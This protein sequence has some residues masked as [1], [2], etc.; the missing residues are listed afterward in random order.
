MD[1]VAKAVPE[2]AAVASTGWPSPLRL[3]GWGWR[4][5]GGRLAERPTSAIA[6]QPGS[7]TPQL[8][9]MRSRRPWRRLCPDVKIACRSSTPARRSA[10][11]SSRGDMQ[12]GSGGIG[13]FLVGLDAGVDWKM[14][15]GLNDMDL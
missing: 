12:V 8:L 14:L 3:W 7:A 9:I 1:L 5:G 6:Y 11:G 15:S 13:P 2:V 10:T 4:G